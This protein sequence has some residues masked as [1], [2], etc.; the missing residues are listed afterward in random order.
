MKSSHPS[1]AT[2]K[3]AFSIKEFCESV[4]IGRTTCYGEIKHGRLKTIKIGR[5]TLVLASEVQAWLRRLTDGGR[6]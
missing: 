6:V 1:G 5:R 3:A 4:S 2:T